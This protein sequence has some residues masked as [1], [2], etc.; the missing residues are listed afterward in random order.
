MKSAPSLQ[1]FRRSGRMKTNPVWV[2]G[3]S[4]ILGSKLVQPWESSWLNWIGA[5]LAGFGG[6]LVVFAILAWRKTRR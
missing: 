5:M 4:M 1:A 6:V 3:L 2:G